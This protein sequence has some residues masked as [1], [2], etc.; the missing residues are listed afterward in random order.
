MFNI[1]KKKEKVVIDK[2]VIFKIEDCIDV[3]QTPEKYQVY[4]DEIVLPLIEALRKICVLEEN[5]IKQNEILEDNK[6]KQGIPKWQVADGWQEMTDQY[7]V[8]YG[9]VVEPICTDKLLER[10][11]ARSYGKPAQYAYVNTGCKIFFIMKSNKK[12]IVETHFHHGIETKHQFVFKNVDGRWLIDE[13]KY[14]HGDDW[15]VYSI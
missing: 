11:Y 5:C 3:S 9:S 4:K 13:K 8:D 2:P 6:I 15:H 12:A 14:G 1:F 7:A 10:G